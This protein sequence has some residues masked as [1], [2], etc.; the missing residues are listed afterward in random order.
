MDQPP[1]VIHRQLIPLPVPEEAQELVLLCEDPDAPRGSFLH[2]LGLTRSARVRAL[3][4]C[5]LGAMST[6]MASASGVGAD[7]SRQRVT[8]QGTNPGHQQPDGDP[9]SSTTE[10]PTGTQR[11]AATTATRPWLM[12]ALALGVGLAAGALTLLGQ[13][14]LT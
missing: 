9:M 6:S 8:I 5:P 2:W 7:R 11:F 14:L 3:A 12:L 1:P 13:K 10:S 4:R